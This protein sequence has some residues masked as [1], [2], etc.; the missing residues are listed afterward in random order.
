MSDNDQSP[1][2]SVRPFRGRFMDMVHPSSD[3]QV[4]DKANYASD[5]QTNV[6]AESAEESDSIFEPVAFTESTDSTEPKAVDTN[7]TAESDQTEET[8]EPLNSPFLPVVKVD[9]RP[10]GA[11][12]P[13]TLPEWLQRGL[14]ELSE[15]EL[16]ADDGGKG[17]MEPELPAE[18][19][20][21]P[22]AVNEPELESEPESEMAQSRVVEVSNSQSL[23]T[24]AA[25][26]NTMIQPQYKPS[27]DNNIARPSSPYAYASHD[28]ATVNA[29]PKKHIPAWAWIVIYLLLILVGAAVGALVYLSGWLG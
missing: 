17:T 4:S 14:D 21:E 26:E 10:L 2:R 19:P 11:A 23:D 28:G 6:A 12:E 16:P 15:L 24:R 13:D 18:V 22:A 27:S 25:L 8:S 3:V 20:A 1:E 5:R 9:K 7:P 29:K